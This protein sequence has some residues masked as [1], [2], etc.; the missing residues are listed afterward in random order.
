MENY[1]ERSIALITAYVDSF[2]DL[3]EIHIRNFAIKKEHL[4][5]VA[6]IAEF[7]SIR[8]EL[9]KSDSSIAKLAAL[10]HDIGR[11]WQLNKYN[12]FDDSKSG[13]HA[14]FSVEILKREKFLK[15]LGCDSEE[16][17]FSAILTHNKFK[18]TENLNEKEL[19][20]AKILRDADKLDILEVLTRFYSQSN[21]KPNHSLAWELP[22]GC[23]LSE[24]IERDIWDGK[25]VQKKDVF[26]EIDVKIMQL[27][28]IYDL[29]FKC[30]IE[31][32]LKRNLFEKIYNS[33][34]Q[35]Y[36]ITDIYR[37]IKE[38]GENKIR[39]Q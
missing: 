36:K 33:L 26:S 13:D 12:T 30:S 4:L 15:I 3:N 2:N 23:N 5:R 11:F 20:H 7:I 18:I 1:T 32:A 27:S 8:L 10:F 35:N 14:E 22:K 6:E 38:F 39:T 31:Y 17:V 21:I 16:V 9:N 28:W 19:L 24:N 37:K 29:N 34:P 25:V